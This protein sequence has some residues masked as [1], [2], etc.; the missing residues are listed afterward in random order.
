MRFSFV[1][2]L[3]EL[4]KSSPLS[5]RM[6]FSFVF[7]LSELWKSSPLSTRTRFSFIFEP[8]ELWKSSP[9]STRT[10]FSFVFEPSELW[11][12]ILFC[13]PRVLKIVSRGVFYIHVCNVLA[14]VVTDPQ[15]HFSLYTH[16]LRARWQPT[17]R[18][19]ICNKHMFLSLYIY[20]LSQGTVV[21]D[22]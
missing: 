11:K 20:R 9:L 17:H 21:T 14:P 2:G 4:W 8:S 15:T 13:Y 10:R 1:F 22:P 16:C 12:S 5:T 18:R 19:S 7:E 3:S 6:R